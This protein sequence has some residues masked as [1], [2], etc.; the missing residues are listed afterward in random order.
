MG[1]NNG[2]NDELQMFDHFKASLDNFLG[3]VKEIASRNKVPAWFND[4]FKHLENF[5]TDFA[6]SVKR[7]EQNDHLLES[8]LGIQ[9]AV[10]DALQ[11]ER[12]NLE[13]KVAGLDAE[14]E[15]LRLYS[16]RPNLLIHGIAE[17]DNESTDNKVMNVLNNDLQLPLSIDDIQRTHRLGRKKEG[18]KRPIILRFAS[19]RKRKMVFDS[20]KKLKGTGTVISE[21]LTKDR[22][23]LY[24]KC[25]NRFKRE[26]V[27]S[28]DGMIYCLTG[29]T[30]LTGRK[31]RL[32]ITREDDLP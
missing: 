30:D 29:K 23:A 15:N 1:E 31:E 13:R 11:D 17:E 19:Y 28:L 10:T 3:N 27:W 18:K 25:I 2:G 9:K 32:I 24:Q 8:Q 4:F 26:N 20:K 5:S 16:R 21:H 12:G 7:L 14:V 22:Y 6:A